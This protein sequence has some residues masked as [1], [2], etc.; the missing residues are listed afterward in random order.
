VLRRFFVEDVDWKKKR[1]E[2]SH[3]FI[4]A[5]SKRAVQCG[6]GVVG[7]TA[8]SHALVVQIAMS[9]TVVAADAELLLCAAAVNERAKA[10]RSCPMLPILVING[11]R[12]DAQSAWE[13]LENFLKLH[14]GCEQPGHDAATR[15]AFKNIRC[16]YEN[17][18]PDVVFHQCSCLPEKEIHIAQKPATDKFKFTLLISML[19]NRHLRT[20]RRVTTAE[21]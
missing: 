16:S 20:E 18:A 10:L 21:D 12:N 4:N 5:M 15:E 19:P 6:F 9:K 13:T 1:S 8:V 17:N 14:R 7:S 11:A 2:D 3:C